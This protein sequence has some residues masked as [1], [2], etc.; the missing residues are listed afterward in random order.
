MFP[1]QRQ[2]RRVRHLEEEETGGEGQERVIR[3]EHRTARSRWSG[4]FTTIGYT[5]RASKIDL[6]GTNS[7]ESD[8]RRHDEKRRG[9]K[10]N[11]VDRT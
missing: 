2:Y 4:W 11:A 5:D 3:P 8:E 6:G 7:G 9:E 10:Y 1:N